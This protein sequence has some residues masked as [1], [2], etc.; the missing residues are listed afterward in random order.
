MV[1]SAETMRISPNFTATHWKDLDLAQ[2][3]CW[4]QAVDILVDRIQGRF[5]GFIDELVT[6]TYSGF[7]VLGLDALLVETLQQ[8]RDGT[9]E[10]PPKQGERKFIEFLTTT[11]LEGFD[12]R[13]AMQFYRDV[14]CGILH[15]AEVKGMNLIR[16]DGERVVQRSANGALTLNPVLFHGRLKQVFAEYCAELR[17]PNSIGARAAFRR[18][19]NFICNV[20]LARADT[21]DDGSTSTV[22]A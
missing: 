13:A 6:H 11:F 17:N 7:V 19:M 9:A 15:Q 20:R 1:S 4:Q 3:D 8:F 2:E 18:K 22:R 16:R 12:E 10:T 14:R 5:I 21:F